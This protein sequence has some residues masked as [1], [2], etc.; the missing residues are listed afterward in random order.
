MPNTLLFVGCYTQTGSHSAAALPLGIS[1]FDF[2]D[3]TGRL[4]HLDTVTGT[5]NPSFLAISSDCRTLY[6]ANE[7]VDPNEGLIS[8]YRIS[9]SGKLSYLNRQPSRGCLP[10]H[11][12]LDR[13]ESYVLAVNYSAGPMTDLPNRSL[14]I[15]PR[16][17][18]GELLAPVAEVSHSG[19]G[20]NPLRQERSHPHSV[21]TTPDNRFAVVADLGIDKLVVYKFDAG[22]GGIGL[23]S[24]V[25]LPPGSGPRHFVF[26]PRLPFAYLVNELTSTMVTLAFDVAAGVFSVG[27]TVSTLPAGVTAVNLSSESAFGPDAHFLYVGNRGHDSIAC[28]KIDSRSGAAT[29]ASVTASGGNTPRHFAIDP[30][31]AFLAVANQNS[32]CISVFRLDRETGVPH[33]IQNVAKVARP[34]CVVLGRTA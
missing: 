22:T 17:T 26:H 14:V 6:A 29:L 11:L 28:F 7:L 27:S 8:A 5:D 18:E 15:Y 1:S 2:D 34:T 31:G 3:A 24:E 19:Q 13:T 30:S 33:P 32:D 10:A 20:P 9:S 16:G 4:T 23:H 25:C 12:C 21:Q